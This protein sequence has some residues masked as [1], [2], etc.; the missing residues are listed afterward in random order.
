MFAA[1]PSD[2]RSGL[3]ASARPTMSEKYDVF[4]VSGSSPRVASSGGGG[5][6]EILTAKHGAASHLTAAWAGRLFTAVIFT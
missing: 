6:R 2:E 4:R 1:L 5:V 3:I